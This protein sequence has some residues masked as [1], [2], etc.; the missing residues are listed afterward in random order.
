MSFKSPKDTLPP[1][2]HTKE[3]VQKAKNEGGTL[4][5][6]IFDG[7]TAVGITELNAF[8][9]KKEIF[10]RMEEPN[11]L[12]IDGFYPVQISIFEAKNQQSSPDYETHQ[13]LLDN[14]IVK[15]YTVIVDGL[16]VK[17]TLERIELLPNESCHDS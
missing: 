16:R 11:L 14:G 6:R 17:G 5:R 12:N 3:T 8:I 15:S 13:A 1:I 9:G 7:S 10:S 2:A 4:S